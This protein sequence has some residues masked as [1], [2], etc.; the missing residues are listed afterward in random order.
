VVRYDFAVRYNIGNTGHVYNPKS[1]CLEGS[2]DGIHWDM[3]HDMPITNSTMRCRS[4]NH[5]YYAANR[6]SNGANADYPE[7]PEINNYTTTENAP[8]IAGATN[9]NINVMEG[10]DYV[11]VA[12]GASLVADGEGLEISSLR[13]DP[14]GAGLIDGF[15]FAKNGTLDV[16]EVEKSGRVELPGVYTN[17]SGF[18]NIASWSL[19]VDGESTKRKIT[20]EGDT[21]VLVNPGMRVILR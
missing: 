15:S 20:I 19:T 12:E 13:V 1:W 17:V 16:T 18:N 6:T 10:F 2:R 5:R 3:L 7:W 9:R 8:E 4:S 11:K 14:S 21:I